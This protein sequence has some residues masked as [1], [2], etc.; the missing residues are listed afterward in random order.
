MVREL[1]PGEIVKKIDLANEWNTATQGGIRKSNANKTVFLFSE[2]ARK[3]IGNENPYQDLYEPNT[4]MILYMGTGK[5][6]DQSFDGPQ[7][8]WQNKS[9]RDHKENGDKL[10]YFKYEDE[11]S[12]KYI[13][14]ANYLT[15]VLID[16]KGRKV[17][18]FVLKIV[19]E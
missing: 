10:H 18:M 9:I 15:H 16:Y 12:V 17:I 7:P 5:D 13:G 3:E 2:P 4:G 8:A 1:I 19:M 11:G 14:E 6:G